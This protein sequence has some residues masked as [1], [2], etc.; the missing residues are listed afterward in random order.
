MKYPKIFTMKV[1][2]A[3]N[4]DNLRELDNALYSDWQRVRTA[5]SAKKWQ[6]IEEE[7]E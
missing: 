2:L 7:E 5:I 4:I 6:A 3:M 1:L